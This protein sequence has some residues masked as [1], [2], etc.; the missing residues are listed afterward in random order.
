[1]QHGRQLSLEICVSAMPAGTANDD[2]DQ[3]D[4]LLDLVMMRLRTADGLCL[5]EV[6][7][8]YRQ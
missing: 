1:M 2:Q 8:S 3:K 6:E 5:K 7:S 4:R